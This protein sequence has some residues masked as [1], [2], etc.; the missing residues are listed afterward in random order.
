MRLHGRGEEG[1]GC[2][3]SE[4]IVGRA[5]YAGIHRV[6]ARQGRNKEGARRSGTRRGRQGSWGRN[7]VRKCQGIWV[8]LVAIHMPDMSL[9]RG[10]GAGRVM[11]PSWGRAG[12][13]SGGIAVLDSRL[14]RLALDSLSHHKHLTVMVCDHCDSQVPVSQPWRHLASFT[15]ALL[16]V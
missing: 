2:I 8:M 13:A 11:R 4:Y 1:G 3:R 10:R 15:F 16:H 14:D 9:G 5:G 12:G 6:Y 7:S